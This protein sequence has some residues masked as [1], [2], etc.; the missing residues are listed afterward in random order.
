MLVTT[1]VAETWLESL[2]GGLIDVTVGSEY[3]LTIN[4]ALGQNYGLWN[5]SATTFKR[6][7]T[8]DTSYP[9]ALESVDYTKQ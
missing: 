3:T 9:T 7:L 1:T 2:Y 6:G 4:A 8:D 5:V